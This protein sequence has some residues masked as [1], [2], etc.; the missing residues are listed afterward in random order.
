MIEK[1][2]INN[3]PWNQADLSLH[4]PNCDAIK[5]EQLKDAI[6]SKWPADQ[7][8]IVRIPY[9]FSGLPYFL[10]PYQ[11][12]ISYYKDYKL[13][14]VNINADPQYINNVKSNIEK[15]LKS[16]ENASGGKL[17]FYED[18][19]G[20]TSSGLSFYLADESVLQKQ[21]IIAFTQFKMN[22]EGF[23][24]QCAI[25]FP[26]AKQFWDLNANSAEV[27]A[28]NINTI[29]HEIGHAA[30]GA[31][32]FH[33]FS[34]MRNTLQ[35]L[36]DGVFCSVMPYQFSIHTD[37]NEC[38]DHCSAP[39][40]TLPGPLDERFLQINYKNNIPPKRGI[41]DYFMIMNVK[42]ALYNSL[43][44]EAASQ[45]IYAYVSNL[46]FKPDVK[47]FSDTASHLITDGASLAGMVYLRCPI[48]SLGLFALGVSAKYL[49]ET[50]TNKIPQPIKAVMNSS[51]TSMALELG[52]IG[53]SLYQGKNMMPM[54]ATKLANKV[55][56][57]TGS[58]IGDQVGRLNA[59]LTSKLAQKVTAYWPFQSEGSNADA[60]DDATTNFETKNEDVPNNEDE[61]SSNVNPDKTLSADELDY[62][63]IKNT[64]VTNSAEIS[65]AEN[66][67][68][69]EDV[70][71]NRQVK[72]M[73]KT[74][75]GSRSLITNEKRAFASS[76]CTLFQKNSRE[77]EL[78]VNDK[79]II[80]QKSEAESGMREKLAFG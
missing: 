33:E 28:D 29:T 41:D 27:A 38:K 58:A 45:G 52:A 4:H 18:K 53:L 42:N 23:I 20:I 7:D 61:I 39:F 1:Q 8:G 64:E 62:S 5:D 3:D 65:K 22:N 12:S 36:D 56:S 47:L 34:S 59:Y 31:Q 76:F 2:I 69:S 79:D 37:K 78:N 63:L 44:T 66:D 73:D 67:K 77:K 25:V 6:I 43:V 74:K 70:D 80:D 30:I 32:H 60:N 68:V 21:N 57:M 17:Q 48:A 24:D 26:G 19:L 15:G 55:G 50:V 13:K 51:Y 9:T 71:D 35:E 54:L 49:P 11:N 16:W 14:P 75:N 46:Y 10:Q 72:E 40:A